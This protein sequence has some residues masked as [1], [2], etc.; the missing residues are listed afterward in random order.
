MRKVST[1]ILLNDDWFTS[2]DKFQDY[3]ANNDPISGAGSSGCNAVTAT[4]VQ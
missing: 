4:R 1:I 3:D 2:T